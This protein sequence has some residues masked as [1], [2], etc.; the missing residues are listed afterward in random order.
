MF[1][2][3]HSN[4]TKPPKKKTH[5]HTTK[6]VTHADRV[7]LNKFTVR[8]WEFLGPAVLSFLQQTWFGDKEGGASCLARARW[9]SW[10]VDFLFQ[11]LE[12]LAFVRMNTLTYEWSLGS[13]YEP[14]RRLVAGLLATVGGACAAAANHLPAGCG[15]FILDFPVVFHSQKTERES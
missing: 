12:F 1:Q 8:S 4:E 13:L 5:T 14:I 6:Q 3:S 2:Q 9:A 10:L 11:G 15:L 7:S